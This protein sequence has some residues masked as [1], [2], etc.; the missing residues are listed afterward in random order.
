MKNKILILGTGGLIFAMLVLVTA[1]QGNFGDN[2]EMWVIASDSAGYLKGWDREKVIVT[3]EKDVDKDLV[4]EYGKIGKEFRLIRGLS[5]EMTD[6]EISKLQKISGIRVYKDKMVHALLDDSV[7]M[8]SADKVH[9]EGITGSNVLVCVVD[10]GIDDSHSALNP[11]V[12]EIDIVN[13][14]SDATDDNGHGTHVAGIIASQNSIYK[15]VAPGVSLMAAKV[16]DS[17]G[18]GY[19]SW[20]ISGIEW[21]IKGPDGI[22]NTGDEADIITLSLGTDYS[23]NCDTEPLGEAV[24][25]AVNQGIVV[26]VAAGNDGKNV[27]LPACASGPIAVGAV[28]KSRN[29]PY[30]SSRGSELDIV[31]PGAD[32]IST[33]INNQWAMGSGTSMA[34]PHV[35]GTSALLLETKPDAT[36]DEIKTALYDTA[37]PVNKC[38]K[39]SFWWGSY[40]YRQRRVTC[41]SEI[42][43]AGIVDAYEAYL[44]IIQTTTT[45]STTTTTVPTITTTIPTTTTSTTIPETTTTTTSTT[46]PTTTTTVPTTTTSTSTT[47]STTSTT[48]TTTVPTTKCWSAEYNYLRRSSSQ[49]KK[50][51]KCAEGN[52]GY[53]SYSYVRG[54]QTAYQYVDRYNN[55]NWETR[56]VSTYYPAYRVKCKDNNWYYTNEDHYYSS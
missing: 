44:Q 15:G 51:C 48:T 53:K 19:E 33:Y 52:Y 18:S 14:D 7:P 56:S 28:D 20:V 32:I 27:D 46:V 37:N 45:T 34:T 6:K 22:D 36:V 31:A 49:F 12:A 24:N 42:T 50:F 13:N 17:S 40:C 47:T 54:R 39:C 41:T 16:L 25:N 23:G 29:V 1:M 30:W 21:C 26:T 35:A 10:T 2:G 5:A 3:F 8:I 55:E 43:G 11:L 38:Y 4:K 9:S